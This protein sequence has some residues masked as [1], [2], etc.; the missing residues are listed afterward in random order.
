MQKIAFLFILCSPFLAAQDKTGLNDSKYLEDQL[1]FNLSYIQMLNAP[2]EI[3]QSGFSFGVYGGFIRDMPL[4]RKRNFG[5][6]AGIGY[7]FSN[8]YFNVRIESIEPDAEVGT[9]KNNKIKLHTVD[10][11]FE[12]RIQKL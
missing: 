3:S 2:D 6:G 5:L 11:P 8:Y 9:L 1:Y 4:N 10:F 12:I 7:G